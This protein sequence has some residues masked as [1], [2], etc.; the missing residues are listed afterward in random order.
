MTA[1]ASAS[2]F[3]YHFEMGISRADFLRLLPFAV[4]G[5]P[6]RVV[7]DR[8]DSPGPPP[9]TITLATLPGRSF[10]PVRIPALAVT[11]TVGAATPEAAQ[12]FVERFLLGYQRA[13]G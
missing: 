5:A 10:G 8:I 12:A 1:G 3:R 2:P 11:L 9:W 6:Q 13:G 4:G 7:G